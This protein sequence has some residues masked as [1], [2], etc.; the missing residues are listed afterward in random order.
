VFAEHR[1]FDASLT[2]AHDAAPPA[3]ANTRDADRK[4]R[5]GWLSADMREHPVMKNLVPLLAHRD[6]GSFDDFFY[7][8][9]ALAN[10][11]QALL[12]RGA[13]GWCPTAGLSDAQVAERIRADG[14]DIL[15]LLAGH[16]DRN[17]PQVAAFRAAPVQVSI[18]D[19]ATS[20]LAAMDYLA[21]DAAMAPVPRRERFTER[22]LRLPNIYLHPR[23]ADAPEPGPPPL[24][25]SGRVTFGCFN[26]PAKL[27]DHVLALWARV[28]AEVPDSRLVLRYFNQFQSPVLRRRVDGIMARHGVDASR[29][30]MGG[31]DTPAA[32][33]LQHYAAID[34]ALDPF[35]FTGS[36][37]TFE[38]LWMGVPVVSLVGQTVVARWTY[39][40]LRQVELGDLAAATP[41]GYVAIA[42]RLAADRDRLV[43]LRR[44]LR[45]TVAAS[46]LC[47]ARRTT[48][49]LE[50]A[51]R[52]MWR[53]WC[54]S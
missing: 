38:A 29:I 25:A 37:T 18:F 35:P 9:P 15:M 34:V 53:K 49:H 10:D 41:D 47:D 42:A 40:M 5:V 32:G 28:L 27:N 46:M 24:L 14:I 8:E 52:A 43:L 26:N 7:A 1:R 6:R 45:A 12:R 4:L 22:P 44:E 20:G 30:D 39:A 2:S 51:Q 21:V 16:F 19:P 54:S 50:R 11:I 48:R 3:F 36:T 17:R 13:A 33:H 31:A 23:P